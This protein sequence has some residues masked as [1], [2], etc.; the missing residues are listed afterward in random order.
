MPTTRKPWNYPVGEQKRGRGR[1]EVI[2]DEEEVVEVGGKAT[3][4]FIPLL[5]PLL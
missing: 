3:V 5:H 2:G 4:F 1:G